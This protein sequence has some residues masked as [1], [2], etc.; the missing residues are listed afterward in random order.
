MD[1][2]SRLPLTPTKKDSVW[3]IVGYSLQKLVKLY[4]SEIVRVHGVRLIRDHLKVASDGQKSYVDLKSRE[5]EYSMGDFMFLKV[6][7]SELPPKLDQI[8]DMF[9]VSMLRHYHSD[10]THVVP[11]E[12][13]EVRLDLIFEEEPV[14]VL[15]REVK[16]LRRKSIPLAKVLWRNHS[17]KQV[18]WEPEDAM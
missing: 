17:S 7:R 18:T 15:D 13:I 14:Q 9:H 6:S 16:V 3:V 4:V 10:P 11:I 5:I 1:F 2:V 12:E 8:H